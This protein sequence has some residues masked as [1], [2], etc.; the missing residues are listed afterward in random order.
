M[1]RSKNIKLAIIDHDKCKPKKCNH[2]CKRQCPV[3]R[4]GKNCIDIEQIAIIYEDMCIGCGICVKACPFNAIQLVNLPTELEDKLV[5]TYNENSFRLY[6]MPIP[7]VGKIYGFIGQNGVGKSTLLNILEGKLKPNYGDYQNENK[8]KDTEEKEIDETEIIKNI[9]NRSKGTELQ[10]YFKLLYDNKLKII[11]KPQNIDRIL[12]HLKKNK[13]DVTVKEL[14]MKFWDQKN[15]MHNRIIN[16]LELNNLL[17]NKAV[18]LSGG[19]LQRLTCAMVMIQKADVYIFDEPSNYLDIKQRLNIANLIKLLNKDDNYI[20]IVEHDLSMLD[21]ISDQV[22]I[23]YG[24]SGA[25]GA[26]SLPYSTSEAINIFFNGYIPKENMKFRSTAYS[27]KESIQIEFENEKEEYAK[28]NEEYAKEIEKNKKE[29]KKSFIINYENGKVVY[30]NFELTIEEGKLDNNIFLLM[31][32]NGTGKSSFLKYIKQNLDF[33]ISYKPQYANTDKY[34]GKNITVEAF[35]MKNI[36]KSMCSPQFITEVVKALSIDKFYDKL[37]DNLSGGEQ[38][39]L[40]IT[41]CLGTDADIYLLDEPSAS[42]DIEQRVIVTKILKRFFVNK[43]KIGFIVEHDIMMSIS[44]SM[45]SSSSIIIF[46]EKEDKEKSN[47]RY[48]IAHSPKLFADGINDFLEKLNITFRTDN[49][50][51]RPRINKLGSQKDT[52]QKKNKNYYDKN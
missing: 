13:K 23:L 5:F 14:L 45:E 15:E 43:R 28:A 39:R 17:D 3:E 29:D 41:V 40:M 37:I 24:K 21:Y 47:I 30:D 38:Q 42:L 49:I 32:K 1:I 51:M 12:N 16:G 8:S 33:V 52:E 50:H 9:L 35:L 26:V 7:K 11:S 18:N 20:F 2:E 6:K 4:S 44:I 36:K 34:K 31:G 19:E 10:K 27:F 46:E 48:S 22:S 25:Y